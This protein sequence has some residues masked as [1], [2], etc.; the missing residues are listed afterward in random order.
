MEANIVKE[1]NVDMKVYVNEEEIPKIYNFMV[2]RIIMDQC[3][4]NIVSDSDIFHPIVEKKA[5]KQ[6]NTTEVDK[7]NYFFQV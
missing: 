1:D 2:K 3:R 7:S 4:V 5:D 6:V